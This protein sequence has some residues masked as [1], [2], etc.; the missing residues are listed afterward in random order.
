MVRR[1]VVVL[2]LAVVPFVA[3][4]TALVPEAGAALQRIFRP[5]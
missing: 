5:A 3:I 1:S 4:P 2:Y